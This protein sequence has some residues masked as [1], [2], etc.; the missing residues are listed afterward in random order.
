MARVLCL[1]PVDPVGIASGCSRRFSDVH[2]RPL[3][4]SA[5]GSIGSN[6]ARRRA[7]RSRS[8]LTVADRPTPDDGGSPPFRSTQTALPG[9]LQMCRGAQR[10]R[11][12]HGRQKAASATPP[13][14]AQAGHV[15]FEV[16]LVTEAH[17]MA[18]HFSAIAGRQFD[19]LRQGLSAFLELSIAASCWPIM[20]QVI[21]KTARATGSRG[22]RPL[23]ASARR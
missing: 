12:Y 4:Q 13:Q 9:M 14:H 11:G 1:E 16:G 18:S 15:M 8:G 7:N 22:S 21:P 3:P 5:T 2:E 20:A 6:C 19:E 10:L 23:A 17:G